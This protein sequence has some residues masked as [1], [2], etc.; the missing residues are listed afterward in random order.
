MIIATTTEYCNGYS[1]DLVVVEKYFGVL[2]EITEFN[3]V[4]FKWVSKKNKRIP[5]VEATRYLARL[6]KRYSQ[7][8]GID[9]N[10]FSLLL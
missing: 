2:D 4:W 1:R 8:E 5:H 3:Y 7:K 9:F 6:G 10:N